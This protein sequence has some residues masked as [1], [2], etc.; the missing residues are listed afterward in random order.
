MNAL[1]HKAMLKGFEMPSI[2]VLRGLYYNRKQVS[3]VLAHELICKYLSRHKLIVPSGF[4]N[5]PDIQLIN[6]LHDSSI[7]F[8]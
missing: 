7:L 5:N 4:V 3:G 6:A 2:T 8:P 1:Y